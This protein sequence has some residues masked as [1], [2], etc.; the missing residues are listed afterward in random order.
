M[1]VVSYRL[2]LVG[3]GGSPEMTNRPGY[4]DEYYAK[5]KE[6]VNAERRRKYKENP[7]Y[8][9]RVLKASRDYR[10]RQRD[11]EDRVRL[12]RYQ[13]PVVKDTGDGG[14]VQL[15]SVGAFAS[16]LGRSV[17][18]INHWEKS[19]ILPPTPYRDGRGFRYYT[20]DMM[21]VVRQAVG[22][23]RRLFPVDENMRTDILRLWKDLGVPVKAQSME[24]ALASTDTSI[25]PAKQAAGI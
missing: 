7:E 24:A 14:A 17:Q 18:A 5:N 19:E 22:T 3:T 11:D 2:R 16:Y 15:F 9:D 1:T 23:K 6:K 21:E 13:T 10:K 20:R 12:P 25:V 8:R 4:F